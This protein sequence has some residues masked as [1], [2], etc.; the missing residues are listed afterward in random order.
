MIQN[1]K[2]FNVNAY[3][4]ALISYFLLVHSHFL[5]YLKEITTDAQTR[6]VY[7]G[8]QSLDD[9]A[10]VW[11][12]YF[13]GAM[14]G[15][16]IIAYYLQLLSIVVSVFFLMKIW[17][18]GTIGVIARLFLTVIYMCVFITPVVVQA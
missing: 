5:N 10:E 15:A 6:L 1:E 8:T 2:Y 16:S 14:E 18:R 4:A 12:D 11:L 17:I 9:K 3:K 13:L 7:F